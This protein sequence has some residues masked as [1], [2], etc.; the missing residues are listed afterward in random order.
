MATSRWLMV[1][2]TSLCNVMNPPAIRAKSEGGGASLS[3]VSPLAGAPVS[4]ARA[5]DARVRS[6]SSA[7]S[8]SAPAAAI[9]APATAL[10]TARHRD[11][12]RDDDAAIVAALGV[13]GDLALAAMGGPLEADGV[14]LVE[15]DLDEIGF[16]IELGLHLGRAGIDRL[17]QR[18]DEA[19]GH[20]AIGLAGAEIADMDRLDHLPGNPEIGEVVEILHRGEGMR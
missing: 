9:R 8:S 17:G 1:R 12:V 2:L 5:G 19:V 3:A 13:L 18:H 14:R 20:Q 6:V 11:L 4:W 7:T 15:V 10:A 16:V